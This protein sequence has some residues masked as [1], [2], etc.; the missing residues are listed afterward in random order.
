M[1]VAASDMPDGLHSSS[2]DCTLAAREPLASVA[3]HSTAHV[4]EVCTAALQTAQWPA[5]VAFCAES[6]L[7][8]LFK[9][10]PESASH[11]AG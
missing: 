9:A 10:A 7:G 4:R 8:A 1:S 11:S 3:V 5:S 2:A 6:A